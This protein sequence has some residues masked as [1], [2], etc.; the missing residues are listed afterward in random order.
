VG[1]HPIAY[2]GNTE[3][4]LRTFDEC[5]EDDLRTLFQNLAAETGAELSIESEGAFVQFEPPEPELTPEQ[6]KLL[7]ELGAA[8]TKKEKT[9]VLRAL[10]FSRDDAGEMAAFAVGEIVFK[11]GTLVGANPSVSENKNQKPKQWHTAT[12]ENIWRAIRKALRIAGEIGKNKRR[13][14]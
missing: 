3:R 7:A 11:D 5:R 8:K 4:L 14:E 1:S 12:W 13:H 10:G 6:K 9:R 2:D